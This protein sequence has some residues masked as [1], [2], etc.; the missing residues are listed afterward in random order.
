MAAA[1]IRVGDALSIVTQSPVMAGAKDLPYILMLTAVGGSPPY[2]WSLNNPDALFSGLS[3]SSDGFIS[4]T[5]SKSG[6]ATLEVNVEDAD[7]TSV[8]KSLY[9]TITG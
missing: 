4:G 9:L 1:V 5:P 8:S 6:N 7:T 3:L 2:T